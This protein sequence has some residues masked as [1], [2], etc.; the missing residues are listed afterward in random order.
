MGQIAVA[1]CSDA[2]VIAELHAATVGGGLS[3]K[4]SR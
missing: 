4:N 3:G 1:R 2:L